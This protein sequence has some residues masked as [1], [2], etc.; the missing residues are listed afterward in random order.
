[1]LEDFKSLPPEKKPPPGQGHKINYDDYAIVNVAPSV[2]PVHAASVRIFTYNITDWNK[3]PAE[4][5]EEAE[6]GEEEEDSLVEDDDEDDDDEDDD[7]DELIPPGNGK[8]KK[9]KGSKRR[10]GH[11]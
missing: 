10:H 1:M 5:E 8:K 6:D 3:R 7:D 4:D 2:V 9:K 11:R